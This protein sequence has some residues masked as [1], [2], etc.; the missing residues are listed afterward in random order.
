MLGC[1][2]GHWV[3]GT[4]YKRVDALSYLPPTIVYGIYKHRIYQD[5]QPRKVSLNDSA[6]SNAADCAALVHRD[7]REANAA[8]FSNVGREDCWAVFDA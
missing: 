2:G 6:I 4:P 3:M 5:I 7:Y 8:E 1:V